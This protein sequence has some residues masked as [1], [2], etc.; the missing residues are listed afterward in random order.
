MPMKAIA[1]LGM[2]LLAFA[3]AA[4]SFAVV[5]APELRSPG[6]EHMLAERPIAAYLHFL[7][8]AI[9]LVAGALQINRRL[10]TNFVRL[11]RWL[12]RSYVIA[13]TFGGAAS[14]AMALHSFGGPVATAGFGLL[15]V[16]WL[17]STL[18]GYYCIR[19]GDQS[20]HRSW[21]MRSYALT[22]AAVTLRLYLPLSQVLGLPIEV[23]YVVI[24]WL[25]WVPNLLIAEW[26]LRLAHRAERAHEIRSRDLLDASH[27]GRDHAR[28]TFPGQLN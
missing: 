23:A 15:G 10:R 16:F 17:G 4:Y 19:Q 20:A 5:F 26:W 11:H 7:G 24:A 13:V 12:G 21:M 9:A 25:C 1:W 22:L 27:R 14:L 8:G 18:K 2:S 28:V 6:V 3:T